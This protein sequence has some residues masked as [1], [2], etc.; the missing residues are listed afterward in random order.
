MLVVGMAAVMDS[1]VGQGGGGGGATDIRRNKL[2]VTNKVIASNVATLTTAETHG[3][4]FGQHSDCC[5]C[6]HRIQ[7]NICA[8]GS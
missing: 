4:S 5:R 7:W 1:A 6:W 3:L 8:D 2:V